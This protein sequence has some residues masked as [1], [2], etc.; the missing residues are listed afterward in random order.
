ML[1]RFLMGAIAIVPLFLTPSPTMAAPTRITL[2]VYPLNLQD[3]TATNFPLC[4]TEITV[5]EASRPYSEGGYTIDGNA[6][7]SWLAKAFQIEQR[8]EFSV[9]WVAKLQPQYANCQA[10]A[11]ISKMDGEPFEGQ[12]YLRMRLINK[13]AYLILDM[14]GMGDA[15]GLT[16][17]ILQKSVKSGN[18]IWTW[19]GTD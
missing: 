9:T 11:K 1:K 4:P 5:T 13:K 16:T 6:S 18:P 17:V 14:T 19:G 3:A 12:S 10:S 8:D 15:N 2:R 7:L